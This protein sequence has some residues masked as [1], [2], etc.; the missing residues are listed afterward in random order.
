MEQ[1]RL[2]HK[3]IDSAG[4]VVR[5][6]TL[7]QI[8]PTKRAGKKATTGYNGNDTEPYRTSRHKNHGSL[9]VKIRPP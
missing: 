8:L 9:P 4:L 2:P 6:G 7:Q 1:E 3:I 5:R